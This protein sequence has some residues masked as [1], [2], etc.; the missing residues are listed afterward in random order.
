MI[1]PNAHKNSAVSTSKDRKRQ[2]HLILVHGIHPSSDRLKETEA[3]TKILLK[4]IPLSGRPA[5]GLQGEP[6]DLHGALPNRQGI[7]LA[8][9]LFGGLTTVAKDLCHDRHVALSSLVAYV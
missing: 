4:S 5:I 9:F 3:S 2:C 6:T 1:I 8:V 7:P